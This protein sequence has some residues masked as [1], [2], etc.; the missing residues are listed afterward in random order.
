MVADHTGDIYYHEYQVNWPT[1]VFQVDD[2]GTF[3]NIIFWNIKSR[4][5]FF[6]AWKM[7]AHSVVLGY[8]PCFLSSREMSV[9]PIVFGWIPLSI[10]TFYFGLGTAAAIHVIMY[11]G[12]GIYFP[13]ILSHLRCTSSHKPREDTE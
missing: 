4:L 8:I 1:A 13:D 3:I 10:H 11:C 9:Y 6:L 2:L 12:L 7:L 5:L